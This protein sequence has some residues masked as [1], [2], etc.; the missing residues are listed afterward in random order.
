MNL[1]QSYA[2]TEQTSMM[3]SNFQDWL[4][5]KF[6]QQGHD[7]FPQDDKAMQKSPDAF[8][9]RV[10]DDV[11]LEELS[12]QLASLLKT[13]LYSYQLRS[14]A[15]LRHLEEDCV[16]AVGM[17]L[18]EDDMIPLGPNPPCPIRFDHVNQKMILPGEARMLT[19]LRRNSGDKPMNIFVD[20]F[21]SDFVFALGLFFM[22]SSF[23][24]SGCNGSRKDAQSVYADSVN[25]YSS[26]Q[27]WGNCQVSIN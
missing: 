17:Q 2:E 5:S 24:F 13:Q 7:L 11:D 16:E 1:I 9:P 3:P 20:P 27:T 4:F 22:L 15:W 18:N 14:V 19:Y 12:K 26:S 8:P 25:C 21:F 6:S 23:S 10:D